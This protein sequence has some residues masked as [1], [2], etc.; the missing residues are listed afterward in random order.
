MELDR[1][2]PITVEI[3]LPQG[4]R[5]CVPAAVV[6]A[7]ATTGALPSQADVVDTTVPAVTCQVDKDGGDDPDVT[8]G[9]AIQVTAVMADQEIHIAGGR[10]VGIV[11]REGLAL[12][13]GE[14][15]I[16]P[17]PRAMIRAAVAEVLPPNRGVH[18][19]VEVPEGK[20][21]SQRTL[22]PRLGIM[23]GISILGTTGIVEPMSEE[24]FK[25]SLEP[26]VDVALAA[27]YRTLILTP[28]R[29]GQR[30]LKERGIP[31]AAVVLMS[32]FVGHLLDTCRQ[33]GVGAVLLWGHLGKLVKLCGGIFHTHSAVADGRREIIAVHAALQGLPLELVR[34]IMEANTAE[35]TIALIQASPAGP[36]FFDYLAEIAAG[37]AAERLQGNVGVVFTN[38]KGEPLGWSQQARNLAAQITTA[39]G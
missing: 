39:T 7:P 19:T 21:V 6:A 12:P 29:M 26:Q 1:E 2:G 16:N 18:L 11:T 23:G 32:N 14:A 34:S 37:K 9:L 24:A 33:K 22:N 13:V 15:A 4:G 5:L 3:P 25:H 30:A 17:V 20:E 28:G 36:G 38:L 10:G 35:E 8:H 31:E 27:G